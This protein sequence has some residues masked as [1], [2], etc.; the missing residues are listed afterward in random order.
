MALRHPRS[1]LLLA[2]GLAACGG[3]GGSP[4]ATAPS[5]TSAQ[6]ELPKDRMAGQTVFDPSGKELTCAPPEKTCAPSDVPIEFKDKCKLAGYRVMQCGCST[7]CTGNV[8][9][10]KKGWDAQ[11]REKACAPE[12]KDCTPPETSAAFQDACSESGHPFMVCGC[13]WLCAGKLKKPVPA[14]PAPE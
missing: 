10:G 4:G 12:Q 3:G 13:E 8:A 1:P 11:N 9:A 6:I 2:F 7:V 14:S 5:A